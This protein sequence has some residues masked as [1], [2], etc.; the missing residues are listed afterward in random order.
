LVAVIKFNDGSSALDANDRRIIKDIA[1]SHS[2]QGGGIRLAGYASRQAGVA[3][4]TNELLANFNISLDRATAVADELV[5][6]GVASDNIVIDA[7]GDQASVN[8][9]SGQFDEADQRRVDVYFTN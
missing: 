9:A 8:V 7:Q 5:R 3:E 4:E 2:R 1:A 6:Q